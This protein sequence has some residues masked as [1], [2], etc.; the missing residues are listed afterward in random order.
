MGYGFGQMG[1]K[2]IK[3]NLKSQKEMGQENTFQNRELL[4]I[5]ENS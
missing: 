3:D 2:C 5:E 1:R 4:S